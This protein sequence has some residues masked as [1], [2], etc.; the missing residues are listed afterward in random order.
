MS[1]AIAKAEGL[2]ATEEDIEKEIQ[3]LSEAYNM[4]V[5]QIKRVLTEDMLKHDITMKKAVEI[6]TGTAKEA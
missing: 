4:P 3:E 1:E 2:E 5:D 6:V